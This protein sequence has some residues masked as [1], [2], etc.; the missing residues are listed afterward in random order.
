MTDPLIDIVVPVY[1]EERVLADSVRALREHFAGFPFR[2]RIVIADN[3]SVDGTQAIGEALAGE[4]EEVQYV[5]IPQKGRGRALKQVWSASDADVVSYMD[6]D[7]STQLAA[8]LP[9]IAPLVSGHAGV[10]IGSRLLPQSKVRLR[11]LK[12]EVL[13]RGYNILIRGSFFAHFHDAQCGFKAIRADVA[14]ELL[15]LVE[16]NGWFLDTELLLLAEH[17]GYRVQEVP[18]DWVDDPDSRVKIA[19]TVS[20]D[21]KGLVRMRRLFWRGGGK[22]KRST[23]TDAGEALAD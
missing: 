10:S 22:V 12:R 1:N 20:G 18:V 4:F 23:K 2:W 17:N 11:T 19:S 14:R 16:D 8:F 9:L 15:P 21:L 6:V 13:S 7:L 3:A 5:R